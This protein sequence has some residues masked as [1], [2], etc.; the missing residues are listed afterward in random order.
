MENA[1]A[2]PTG[3]QGRLSCF[4][5][6]ELLLLELQ[7]IELVVPALLVQELL[8]GALLHDLAVGQDDGTVWRDKG[9]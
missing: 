2:E 8:M 4:A 1:L 3:L 6:L 5:L 7:G 9:R